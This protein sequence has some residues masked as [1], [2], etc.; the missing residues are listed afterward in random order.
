MKL[1]TSWQRVAEATYSNVDGSNVHANTRFYLK[2]SERDIANNS[3]TIYWEYRAIATPDKDWATYWY[4]Y[5][6]TY[7]IYDGSTSRASGSYQEGNVNRYEKVI[8]S[9]SWTQKHN[10]DGKWSTTL[11]FNGHVYGSSYK[12]YVDISLPTIPREAKITSAPDFNDEENPIITYENKA[13]SSVD[14]LQACISLTGSVDNIEYRDVPKTGTLSY[15][16]ELTEEERKLLRKATINNPTRNV[17]FMIKT[18]IGE[19]EYVSKSE[20]KTLTIINADPDFNNFEFA[21]INP[22]TVKLLEGD[23]AISSQS[24]ILGYSNIK[25]TIPVANKAVAQ[26]E[27]TMSKY[28]FNNNEENYSDTETVSITSNGV[29]SGDFS[30]YAIDSRGNSKRKDKSAI[31]VIDYKPLQKGNITTNRENGTSEDV[32][33]NIDGIINLINFGTKTNSILSAQYRYSIA[34]KNEWSELA[35][36]EIIVD[37]NGNFSFDGKIKGDTDTLGFNVENAYNIEVYVKDELSEIKYTSN[38]G[39]GIPHI[40]YAKNGVSIMGKYDES[41]GGLLQV[42]G[43]SITST[44]TLPIGAIVDYD[45]DTVPSGYELVEDDSGWLNLTFP[46]TSLFKQY[47][48]FQTCQYRKIGDRLI[49]RGMI[50]VAT[51][52]NNSTDVV[53][54]MQNADYAP[55]IDRYVCVATAGAELDYGGYPLNLIVTSNGELKVN[56]CKVKSWISLDGLEIYL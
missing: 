1:T 33:L 3:H 34:G 51:E 52:N 6:K 28:R 10:S 46:D 7:S 48:T 35:N 30:V 18:I 32:M 55:S 2:R 31:N 44:D 41:V 8:A 11:T 17:Y 26:K 5:T 45:G 42:G 27:A 38:I 39:A 13:G 50:D 47:N 15:T 25:V 56:Y 53:C 4:N 40:A 16:F 9:G 21:D 14:L 54:K 19:V 24:V 36:L 22:K 37:E 43:K 49:F 29:T 12:R 20:A 23:S